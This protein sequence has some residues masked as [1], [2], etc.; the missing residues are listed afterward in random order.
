MMRALKTLSVALFAAILITAAILCLNLINFVKTDTKVI[1][2]PTHVRVCSPITIEVPSFNKYDRIYLILNASAPIRNVTIKPEGALIPLPLD[3]E[4]VEADVTYPLLLSR[5]FFFIANATGPAQLIL[6]M[7]P[8]IPYAV[9]D[10]E[11]KTVFEVFSYGEDDREY[12]GIDVKAV[13]FAQNGFTQ[14]LL[15]HPL[16]EVIQPDFQAEGELKLLEG[17]VAY[18]NFI[19]MTDTAWY[20]FNIAPHTLKPSSSVRFNINAGTRELF[21]RTG[22]FLGQ[23]GL[24]IALG[25]GLHDKQF[26]IN[27]TARAVVAIGDV[28]VMNG[29]KKITIKSQTS[30]EYDLPYR[31]YVFHKF[32][33]TLEHLLLVSALAS[34]VLACSYAVIRLW[35]G[36]GRR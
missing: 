9:K 27:E 10:L 17:K 1:D 31:L 4:G 32:Q 30:Y 8:K 14:T 26:S 11:G 12:V 34:E 35:R 25:I 29:G 36:R 21:N 13:E 5:R 19:I 33:P 20:A 15:V 23:R 3:V 28:T 7:Q 18:V 2:A 22:A 24:F 6:R 16:N